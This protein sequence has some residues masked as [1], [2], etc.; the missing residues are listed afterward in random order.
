MARGA[1][2]PQVLKKRIRAAVTALCLLLI[3]GG[4]GA[5]GLWAVGATI[6]DG[7]RARDWIGVAARV[8][9]VS[10]GAVRY[11]YEWKGRRYTGDRAGTFVL[12]GSSDVDDW[13]DRMDAMLTAA[14]NEKKPVTV[15]VDPDDPA[16]SILD[17]EIRW[18]L[19]L[20]FAPFGLAF[21]FGG[22]AAAWTILRD[23]FGFSIGRGGVP[24]LRAQ[25]RTALFQWVLA[26]VWNSIVLSVGILA[27][28]EMWAAAEWFPLVVLVVF[29]LIGFA[30]LRS[31]IESTVEVV[32]QGS[33]FNERPA[34]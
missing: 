9:H 17:R 19:L 1:M 3:F 20:V 10:E 34:S 25:A 14:V 31:A 7:L 18:K 12:G 32:R 27:V 11:S 21:A 24:L 23:A 29:A 28:P 26:L 8:E 30:I 33:P 6:A 2:H 5:V 16:Q 4:V 13:E 15:Y 22:I